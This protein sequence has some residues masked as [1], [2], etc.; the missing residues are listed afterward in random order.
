MMK[1]QEYIKIINFI[2]QARAWPYWSFVDFFL[3]NFYI[4]TSR[5]MFIVATND[6][7]ELLYS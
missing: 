6:L 7:P 1:K 5:H 2:T 3:L 4:F